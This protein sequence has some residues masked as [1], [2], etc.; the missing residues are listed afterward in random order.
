MAFAI[1]G[2]VALIGAGVAAAGAG[3]KLGVS[4]A[5]RRKRINEQKAAKAEM[6]K[7]KKEYQ[8]LDTSNLA[9][10]F[11]NPY[12]NMENT[13]EDLKVNTQQAEFEAQQFQ[14][15]QANIMQGIS[16]NIS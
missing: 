14:Q 2:T 3:A 16:T 10:G 11:K 5:G 12:Q 8:N 4:L 15:S 13:M 1:A 7:M 6:E 9:A